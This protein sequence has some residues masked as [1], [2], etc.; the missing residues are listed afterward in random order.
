MERQTH[1]ASPCSRQSNKDFTG[2][3]LSWWYKTCHSR[4]NLNNQTGC[5][6]SWLRLQL[7]RNHVLGD[8]FV[9]S[10]AWH[11][12]AYRFVKFRSSSPG[13]PRAKNSQYINPHCHQSGGLCHSL[14]WLFHNEAIFT[15][16]LKKRCSLNS[17]HPFLRK[18]FFKKFKLQ[19][20]TCIHFKLREAGLTSWGRGS[21]N[22]PN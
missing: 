11:Q 6:A 19:E 1:R 8:D 4:V 10:N 14:Q 20:N 3:R 9:S 12:K 16:G 22:H 15:L 21:L 7:R 2:M 5:R 18:F 17:F 13:T